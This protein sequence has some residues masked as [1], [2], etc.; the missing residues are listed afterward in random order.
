[1]T[2]T[3]IHNTLLSHYTKKISELVKQASSV[4]IPENKSFRSSRLQSNTATFERAVAL[5]TRDLDI[6]ISIL[7]LFPRIIF[8]KYMIRL[9]IQIRP[10]HL[11]FTKI[12][13]KKKFIQGKVIGSSK[14]LQSRGPE[15]IYSSYKY[16]CKRLSWTVGE[17]PFKTLLQANT[18]LSLISCRLIISSLMDSSLSWTTLRKN[19]LLYGKMSK[20][21]CIKISILVII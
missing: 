9:C 13:F 8:V 6:T 12:D 2:H 20:Y 3:H 18:P 16:A 7:S 10:S 19:E 15:I 4:L 21:I 11:T 17:Q 5:K 1:M 14:E